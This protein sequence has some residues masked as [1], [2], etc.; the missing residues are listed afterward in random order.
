[1]TVDVGLSRE[2]NTRWPSAKTLVAV[3]CH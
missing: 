2:Y 3:A 1:M